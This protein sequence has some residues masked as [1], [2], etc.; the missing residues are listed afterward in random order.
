MLYKVQ[1]GHLMFYKL[2]GS[3]CVVY[4]NITPPMWKIH[5][6]VQKNIKTLSYNRLR[7]ETD[8]LKITLFIDNISYWFMNVVHIWFFM[9]HH[10]T[11]T[12]SY[13]QLFVYILHIYIYIYIYNSRLPELYTLRC[14]LHHFSSFI[15]LETYVCGSC[16]G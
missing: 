16:S 12:Q 3:T 9:P 13:L 11:F 15:F 4:H 5:T 2:L 6:A 7:S 10:A 1:L 8:I 14:L